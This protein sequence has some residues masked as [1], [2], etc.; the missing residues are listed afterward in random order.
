MDRSA[1]CEHSEQMTAF[2]SLT[3]DGLLDIEIDTGLSA[4]RTF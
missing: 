2:M 4:I 3:L 1:E